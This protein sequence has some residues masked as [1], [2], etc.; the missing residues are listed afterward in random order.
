MRRE[1]KRP[2]LVGTVILGF[3]SIFKKSQA[4]SPFEVLNSALLSR[5]QRDVRPPVQMRQS[6]K[7]FC[8]VCTGDSLN[9]SSREMKGESAF[10][11]LQ[12]NTTFS[13]VRAPRYSLQL[14][15][16]T[17][18]RSPIHIAEGRLLL[19]YL[20]KVGLPLQLTPGNQLSCP[21]DMV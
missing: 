14:R 20:W 8:R 6:P 2:F 19:R 5:C 11:T 3:L 9:P 4:P 13:R 16:Q 1:T 18:G 21:D 10:K 17:Q 15:Q 12:G 7:P